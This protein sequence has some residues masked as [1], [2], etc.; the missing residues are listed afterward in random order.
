MDFVG[1]D[2]NIIYHFVF[3]VEFG[4]YCKPTSFCLS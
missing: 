1:L 4:I 3:A 2:F